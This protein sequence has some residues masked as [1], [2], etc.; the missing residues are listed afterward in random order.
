MKKI[1]NI[2]L[3]IAAVFSIMISFSACEKIEI[4]DE[5]EDTSKDIS[6]DD[7]DKNKD[8]DDDEDDKGNNN[9]DD[10]NNTGDNDDTG[11]NNDDNNS[12]ATGGDDNSRPD[13]GEDNGDNN[14]DSGD[15]EDNSYET[16]DIVS[17]SEF[18][19]KDITCE[20]WLVGRIVGDCTR[21]T[22]YAEFK[23]PFTHSQAI[24]LADDPNETNMEKIVSVC[25][26]TN[27]N[28]RKE[29]NLVDHPHNKGQYV[30]VFGFKENYLGLYGIK[31]PCGYEFPVN[32]K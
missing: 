23:E 24:L 21:S 32:I 30:A 17:V 13:D 15:N 31:K 27:K 22:K 19:K 6:S 20:I 26:T 1:S 25:L 12:D 16:G 29:L 2:T 8:K 18:I 7:I 5:K 4:E 14:E 11:G 28:M 9:K 3:L 10:D